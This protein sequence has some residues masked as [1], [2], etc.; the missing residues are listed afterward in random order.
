MQLG[1]QIVTIVLSVIL[2]AA[3]LMQVKGMAGSGIFGS[4]YSTFRARRGFERVLFRAT[5][6]FMFIFVVIAL[7]SARFL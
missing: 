7:L 2:V 6:L 5:I 4:A 3:I 1:L